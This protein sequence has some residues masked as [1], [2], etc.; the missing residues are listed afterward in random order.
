MGRD[1]LSEQK[2]KRPTR[3]RQGYGAAGAQRS[4]LNAQC[5]MRARQ[6]YLKDALQ[7]RADSFEC[8]V[9]R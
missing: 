9:E 7:D 5:R 3:L 6:F 4:T 1:Q 2:S 8:G